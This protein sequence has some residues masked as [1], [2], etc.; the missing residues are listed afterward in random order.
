MLGTVTD[1]LPI[2]LGACLLNLVQESIDLPLNPFAGHYVE[3][4]IPPW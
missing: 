4:V 3:I 2:H 1:S